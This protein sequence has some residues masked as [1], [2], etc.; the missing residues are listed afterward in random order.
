MNITIDRIENA[1]LVYIDY[2]LTSS[3][4]Y[5]II[6]YYYYEDLL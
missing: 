5:D 2:I 1:L 4:F 3:N 6:L